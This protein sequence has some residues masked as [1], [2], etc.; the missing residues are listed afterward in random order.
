M[1][2]QQSRIAFFNALLWQEKELK[3]SEGEHDKLINKAIMGPSNATILLL[4][5][6]C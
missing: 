1:L 5:F 6:R 3:L 4:L 2:M